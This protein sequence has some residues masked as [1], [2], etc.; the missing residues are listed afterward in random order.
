MDTLTETLVPGTQ[1]AS[2]RQCSSWLSNQCH[3]P[4][5]GG[6]V[7]TVTD[8]ST[9]ARFWIA[10]S[11]CRMIGWPTPYV[12]R[13]LS[14][15]EALARRYGIV[16]LRGLIVVKLAVRSSCRPPDE[17]AAAATV[18]DLAYPSGWVVCQV[19]LPV[20]N[21]PSTCLPTEL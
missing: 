10:S 12:V 3:L 7:A 20:S 16:R 21:T 2:G 5:T 1:Y 11:K 19:R 4:R 17:V 6:S 18:Y 13:S 8:C 14:R 15:C 9:T